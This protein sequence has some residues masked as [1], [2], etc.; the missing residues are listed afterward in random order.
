MARLLA[1][2]P[3]HAGFTLL[4]ALLSISIIGIL[5]G[6]SLPLYSAMQR[7]GDLTTTTQASVDK[8][9]LAQTYARDGYHGDAWSVRFDSAAVTLYKG[10]NYSS[11]D[12]SYDEVFAIPSAVSTP[13]G[14]DIHFQ[15]LTGFPTASSTIEFSKGSQSDTITINDKGAILY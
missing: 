4:E 7:R 9:R 5:T 14:T 12:S 3:S 11:R 6:I 13:G 10:H 15:E 8:L 1:V 2:R